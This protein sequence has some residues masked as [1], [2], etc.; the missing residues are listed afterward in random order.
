MLKGKVVIIT[1][2]AQGIGQGRTVYPAITIEPVLIMVLQIHVIDTG[3]AV[4]RNVVNDD[5]L[6]VQYAE[7][8]T[9]LHRDTEVRY[10]RAVTRRHSAIK[11]DVPL[12]AFTDQASLGT[13]KINNDFGIKLRN[14]G[15]S[16]VKAIQQQLAGFVVLQVQRQDNDPA[17]RL[18]NQFQQAPLKTP[19]GCEDLDV[20]MVDGQGR[21][22]VD[23][24]M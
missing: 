17:L 23:T 15:L 9:I 11:I 10:H 2:A 8:F 16:L 20:A 12:P 6:Q 22:A 24:G 1:G 14:P 13:V 19:R 21:Q 18:G 5:S 7:E 4:K 3:S